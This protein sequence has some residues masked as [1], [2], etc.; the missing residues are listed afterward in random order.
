M[1]GTTRSS[2]DLDVRRRQILFRAWHRGMREMDLIMGRFADAEIGN[3]SEDEVTEFER[4]IEV[5][6][7]DLL[8]W[9]TGEIAIPTNYDTPLF[10]RLK[11]FHTHTSP[12]HN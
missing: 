4:L 12:I 11:G 6:D 9:V 8:G 1:S 10:R 3:L 5:L 7:R 2:A